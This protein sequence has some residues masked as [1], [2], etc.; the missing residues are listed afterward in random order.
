MGTEF[1]HQAAAEI[2]PQT[3]AN[4]RF[5]RRG[6][7][8]NRAVGADDFLRLEPGFFDDFRS[9]NVVHFGFELF[10]FLHPNVGFGGVRLEKSVA[11]GFKALKLLFQ[12]GVQVEV[13]VGKL[14]VFGIDN[15][16]RNR[17]LPGVLFREVGAMPLSANVVQV[18]QQPLL[19]GVERVFVQDVVVTLMPGRHE[20]VSLFR[21]AAHELAQTNGLRH[22]F[23]GQ[24][25]KTQSH[26]GNGRRR[27][28]V[29][30]QADNH[31]FNA[32]V[33]NVLFG[34]QVA[35]VAEDFNVLTR[36][37]FVFPA[38]NAAQAE[39]G[40]LSEF[41]AQDVAVERA[42]DAVRTNVGNSDNFDKLG[43]DSAEKDVA[44]VAGSQNGNAN[45]S[46]GFGISV[47]I[48]A[49]PGFGSQILFNRAAE[50]IAM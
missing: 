18:A 39:A 11:F 17:R 28:K 6:G 3:P 32:E 14:L 37:R 49:Q 23:F 7:I 45:R 35:V 47:I 44:F 12:A 19:N 36:F 25:V 16:F 2:V 43:V 27:V 22:E 15:P 10:D 48:P 8:V 31:S 40:F 42:G 46:V 24:N 38:V 34:K 26:G 5:C 21:N 33:F 1:N 41:S 29:Q 4:H 13:G 9:D 20:F 30:R 50:E